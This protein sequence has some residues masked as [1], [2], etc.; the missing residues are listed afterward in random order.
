MVR[1][2][3]ELRWL[4]CRSSLLGEKKVT[5]RNIKG[6]VPQRCDAQRVPVIQ[7][8]R[9]EHVSKRIL[10]VGED[11]DGEGVGHDTHLFPQKY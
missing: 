2:L 7:I 4:S 11:Q 9:E 8:W 5:F 3:E 1:P 10:G 6:T